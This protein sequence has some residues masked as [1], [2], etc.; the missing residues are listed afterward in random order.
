MVLPFKVVVSQERDDLFTA[1]GTGGVIEK[2]LD[3]LPQN[4]ALFG[5]IDSHWGSDGFRGIG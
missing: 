3:I 2:L 1:Q 4:E 5:L